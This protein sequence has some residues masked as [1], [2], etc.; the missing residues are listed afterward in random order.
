FKRLFGAWP[1]FYERVGNTVMPKPL[2]EFLGDPRVVLYPYVPADHAR[3]TTGLPVDAVVHIE[4]GWVGLGPFGVV[5]ETRFA[6]KLDFESTGRRL[7]AIVGHAD[8]RHA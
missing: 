6:D 4:A 3:D 1:R 2:K 7:H 5:G 8:L